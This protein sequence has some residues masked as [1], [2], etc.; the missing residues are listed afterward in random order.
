MF[1]FALALAAVVA[2]FASPD[3]SACAM[4]IPD[5][6]DVVAALDAIDAAVKPDAPAPAM[7]ETAEVQA[8]IA[9]VGPAVVPALPV[10]S[11]RAA[12]PTAAVQSKS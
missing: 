9:P 11:P 7:V 4:Y 2:A 12:P 6:R 3:A 1:R 10:A 5:D 8:P